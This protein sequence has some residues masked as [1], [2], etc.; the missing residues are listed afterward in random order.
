MMISLNK[1]IR[2]LTCSLFIVAAL[3]FIISTANA[4]TIGP[5]AY[6]SNYNGNG[7]D[8]FVVID[9]QTNTVIST[10]NVTSV[11]HFYGVAVSPDGTKVYM[12]E[13]SGVSLL[14]IN[15]TNQINATVNLGFLSTGVAVSPDGTKVY[16][17]NADDNSVSVIDAAT[18]A[19]I[20]KN[21]GGYP[22]GVAVSPDGTKI[23]VA[24]T[25]SG[26]VSVINSTN[27]VNA[28]IPLGGSTFGVAVSPDGTKVY[29]A[30]ADDNS[31]SVIDAATNAVITNVN[32][33][34]YPQGVAVSPDG[35]K[36]YVANYNDG[37][38]SIINSTNQVSATVNVGGSPIGV[39][40]SPDGTK[41]YVANA[42]GNY[43]SVI[44][45]ATNTV[46]T[47]VPVY[48]RPIALGEFIG[49]AFVVPT[50]G[51]TANRT[52]GV[53]SLCVRFTD[54]STG[55]P[56]GWEWDFG[57]VPFGTN[58]ST[59]PDPVHYYSA[60]GT[61]NVTL[62][63]VNDNGTS[64]LQK[65]GYIVVSAPATFTPTPTTVGSIPPHE[66]INMD[67]VN[68][69]TPTVTPTPTPTPAEMPTPSPVPSATSTP[70]I[71]P[72]LTPTPSSQAFSM[73]WLVPLLA[74]IVVLIVSAYFYMRRGKKEG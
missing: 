10:V 33:G 25:G 55:S 64:T 7:G 43:V 67:Y 27:Q 65:T 56:S 9:T 57:D 38:V 66:S 13:N 36:I 26:S 53:A 18:N 70:T 45:A 34:G 17:A 12:T 63:T 2:P 11:A 59:V 61:Y 29:V 62:T 58:N 46:I 60:P 42:G 20:T 6:I 21:V 41:V 39:A 71:M 31:V 28:T 8:N 68:Q 51:F 47:N 49:P 16:V 35:N 54:T 24:N 52:S 44:D 5:Y 74:V 69:T 40:V 22:Q 23:Y 19:V 3:I 50:T 14:V 32:V 73:C 1:I 15:S 37:T 30:N 48:A 4:T 72:T